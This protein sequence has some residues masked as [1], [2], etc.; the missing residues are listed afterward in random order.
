L[1]GDCF[2]H[3]IRFQ[4]GDAVAFEKFAR[5]IGA[6]DLEPLCLGMI[7]VNKTQVVKQRSDLE[8]FRVKFQVLA[9]ALYR[10]EQKD[11]N[12]VVE[13]QFGFVL[14]HQFSGF[15][16]DLAVRNFNAGNHAPDSVS[17]CDW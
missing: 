10:S 16:R 13:Q 3:Q 4:V 11:T 7:G 6:V 17:C 8:Q 12:R 2:P 5:C 1:Q 9:D 15:T 14:P